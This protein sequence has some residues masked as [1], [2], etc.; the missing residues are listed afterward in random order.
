MFILKLLL[1]NASVDKLSI[2]NALEW[3]VTIN[4]VDIHTCKHS[5]EINDPAAANL[6]LV[7]LYF[8]FRRK[9]ARRFAPRIAQLK[10]CIIL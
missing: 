3:L 6:K 2:N 9:Y 1:A 8:L 7:S 4:F 10:D 5:E